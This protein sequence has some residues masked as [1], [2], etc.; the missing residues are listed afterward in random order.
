MKNPFSNNATAV[1]A[2]GTRFRIYLCD[3]QDP[4]RELTK[5]CLGQIFLGFSIDEG[6]HGLHAV[7]ATR[8]TPYDLILLDVTMPHMDGFA[9]LKAIRDDSLN[10]DTPVVMV[11]GYAPPEVAPPG[12]DPR[13]TF[14][15][16]KPFDFDT[17]AERLLG[18]YS[19]DARWQP[20]LNQERL[21]RLQACLAC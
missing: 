17:I 16:T 2:G 19:G 15:L 8:T 4:V 18:L 10:R 11:T 14:Y 21:G 20:Y 12:A 5:A 6:R 13:N 3:D 9:A 7:E 1:S